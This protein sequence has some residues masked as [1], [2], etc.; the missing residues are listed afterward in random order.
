MARSISTALQRSV[1]DDLDSL[2]SKGYI[3]RVGRYY[4]LTHTFNGKFRRLSWNAPALTVDTRFGDPRYF[5]H[6]EEDRGFTV[7][8]VARVQG[9]PDSYIFFGRERLSY[10]MLGNAVPPPMARSIAQ[11]VRTRLLI[12]TSG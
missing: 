10:T 11:L 1:S 4:D 6:P 12:A 3:R 2:L 5:L 8:E 9:F 7:R